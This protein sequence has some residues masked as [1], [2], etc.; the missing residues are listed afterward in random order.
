MHRFGTQ[1]L[2]NLYVLSTVTNGGLLVCNIATDSSSVE[3]LTIPSGTPFIFRHK[4]IEQL[5][6]TISLEFQLVGYRMWG[7]FENLGRTRGTCT[8]H[9]VR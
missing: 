6:L 3:V 1:V 5:K 9:S 8:L 2:V 7:L 4:I